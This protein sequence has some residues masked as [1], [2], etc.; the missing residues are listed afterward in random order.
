MACCKWFQNMK[1]KS[2]ILAETLSALA[3]RLVEILQ[4]VTKSIEN[5]FIKTKWIS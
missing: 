5:V 3:N 2:K 4:T 1:E